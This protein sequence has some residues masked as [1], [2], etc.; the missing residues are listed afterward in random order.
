MRITPKKN[1]ICSIKMLRAGPDSCS[2]CI[3]MFVLF[4]V[5]EKIDFIWPDP[6][7]SHSL[8]VIHLHLA[9]FWS[10]AGCQT[11]PIQVAWL[12]VKRFPHL[13]LN[14]CINLGT[15]LNFSGPRFYHYKMPTW[16][17]TVC[18]SF[19]EKKEK[20]LHHRGLIICSAEN[21]YVTRHCSIPYQP[22]VLGQFI[23][24]FF[25]SVNREK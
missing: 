3:P 25:A 6:F 8:S 16:H 13:P 2:Y 7:P 12:S 14:W 22:C 21:M 23:S 11:G 20:N 1:V 18:Q 4:L 9:P 15:S 24:S 17:W 5:K 19:Q 10:S